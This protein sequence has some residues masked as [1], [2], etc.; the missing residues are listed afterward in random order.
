MYACSERCHRVTNHF[1][2]WNLH[3]KSVSVWH[4]MGLLST[5]KFYLWRDLYTCCCCIICTTKLGTAFTKKLREFNFE[6]DPEINTGFQ[7]Q[8]SHQPV[9][10][11]SL[12]KEKY[13]FCEKFY[14]CA[15]LISALASLDVHNFSHVKAFWNA[16]ISARSFTRQL[17]TSKVG[18]GL[19]NTVY[20]TW[21]MY[22]QVHAVMTLESTLMHISKDPLNISPMR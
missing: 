16:S 18:G 5:K 13:T 2:W 3:M 21:R 20:L 22:F 14:L 17:L 11:I 4:F 1:L 6:I 19:W 15:N 12:G 8:N 10:W 7:S 9:K